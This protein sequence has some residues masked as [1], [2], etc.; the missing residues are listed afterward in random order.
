MAGIDQHNRI[1]IF[2]REAERL[3]GCS[4]SVLV[5]RDFSALPA[6]IRDIVV[7]AKEARRDQRNVEKTLHNEATGESF[8]VLVHTSAFYDDTQRFLGIQVIFSD[9]TPIK[10]LEEN[11]ARAERLASLVRAGFDRIGIKLRTDEGQLL[12]MHHLGNVLNDTVTRDDWLLMQRYADLVG[13]SAE[14]VL[15][16]REPT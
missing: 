5:G 3:T 10:N 8:R 9:I 16:E 11:I 14:Q 4:S 2:N 12:H 15:T 13:V 6:P 1:I 7:S